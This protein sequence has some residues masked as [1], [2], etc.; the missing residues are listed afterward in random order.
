MYNAVSRAQKPKE[1]K[2]KPKE[3]GLAEPAVKNAADIYFT[4]FSERVPEKEN[5]TWVKVYLPVLKENAEDYHGAD[6]RNRYK[7]IKY[8]IVHKGIPVTMRG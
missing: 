1:K 2:A 8:D 7:A 3:G 6:S 5:D 4:Y